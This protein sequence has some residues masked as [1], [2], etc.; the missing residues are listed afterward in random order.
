MLGSLKQIMPLFAGR[1]CQPLVYA[2]QHLC[3]D[4]CDLVCS[5]H[6]HYVLSW[7]L[8]MLSSLMQIMPPLH[9]SSYCCCV[10]AAAA[11][12]AAVIVSGGSGAVAVANCC[13]ITL[14]LL[15]T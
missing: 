14:P 9:V 10:A 5:L 12:A 7:A 15:S 13:H 4:C 2:V 3:L 6:V 11:A 8:H 1:P